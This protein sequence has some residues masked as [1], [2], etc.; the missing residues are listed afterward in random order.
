MPTDGPGC[1]AA[2]KPGSVL[3]ANARAMAIHLG[4]RL[5]DASCGPPGRQAGGGP[6]PTRMTVPRPVLPS[7]LTLLPVGLAMPLPSPAVRWAL[8]PPFHPCPQAGGLFS[9]ALSLR[10]RRKRGIPR[11]ALPGTVP[12]RS[13]DFPHAASQRAAIRPP[14][15]ASLPACRDLFEGSQANSTSI[16]GERPAS[17]PTSFTRL[18]GVP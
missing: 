8:T 13:P 1:Q 3:R 6:A 12:P 5:P 2:C 4:R 17:F 7:L 14:D 9:V 10:F 11:R 18:S 16:P 15:G